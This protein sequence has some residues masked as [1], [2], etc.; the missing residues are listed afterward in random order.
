[1]FIL[2]VFIFGMFGNFQG[3]TCHEVSTSQDAV[4]LYRNQ[5]PISEGTFNGE[6][7]SSVP[8]LFQIKFDGNGKRVVVDIT[9]QV[10]LGQVK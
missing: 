9:E 7:P 4:R 2:V 10:E 8:K 6:P 5:Y 1:M 3:V